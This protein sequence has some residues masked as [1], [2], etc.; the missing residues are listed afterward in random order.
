MCLD[1]K[2]AEANGYFGAEPKIWKDPEW[3]RLIDIHGFDMP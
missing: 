3:R 2:K 1:M